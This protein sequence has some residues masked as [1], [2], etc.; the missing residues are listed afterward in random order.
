MIAVIGCGNMASAIVKGIN[1][2]YPEVSF[3]TYTPSFTRAQKL[4]NSVQGKAVKNLK[5][6]D[7]AEILIIACK[8]QQFNQFVN[9]F[10]QA[11]DLKN[12][13]IV[14]IMAAI[15]SDTI[16]KKLNSK[17]IIR[18]MPNTPALIGKG[19]SL[20]YAAGG[21]SHSHKDLIEKYFSACSEV[22][23]LKS[24]KEFDEIT[25]IS[26]SGPA[27]VF[28]FAKTLADKLQTLGLEDQLSRKMI[29]QL[30]EGAIDLIKQDQS[31]SLDK[32]ISE[33]TSKGG[34]TI[35]AIKTYQ[36]K[37][38]DQITNDAIDAAIKRSNEITQEFK[39]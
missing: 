21:V 14:S 16:A 8:P 23:P 5:E 15:D 6:L 28:Y 35:E 34:V 10:N 9:D 37:N 32:L 18:I 30:F 19:I 2:K 24:E 39:N 4:A 31:K 11:F 26:G 36:D 12:K 22:Y 20:M 33:V 13:L 38:L 7:A 27:Y 29:T 25:T 17:N 3:L 1:E